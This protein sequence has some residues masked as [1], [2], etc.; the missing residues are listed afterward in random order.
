MKKIKW[1][2]ILVFANLVAINWVV[3]RFLA[4]Y[5]PMVGHDYSL[6]IPQML[7]T[8]IHLR[9]NGLSIQWYTP[10]FGGGLP[11][12]PNPN[13]SQFS[14]LELLTVLVQPWDAV[15]LSTIIYISLGG[16]ASYYLFKRVMRLH[17]TSSILGM[18]FFSANG[19]MLE[20]IA[21]GHLGY[22]TFPVIAILLVAL[23]DLSL[24]WGIAALAFAFVVTMLLHQAGYFI[25]VTFGLSMLMIFPL[26]YILRSG[27]FSWKRIIAVI[28]LGGIAALLM[29]ASKLAAVFSFMRFFP[30]EVADHYQ[31][32]P[33]MGL[34]GIALQLLGTMNLT[35]L[36][37]AARLDPNLLPKYLIFVTGGTYGY[38]EFDMSM[39]PAVFVILIAGVYRFFRN[40]RNYFRRLVTDR[41]WIAWIFL[42]L[43]TWITIEFTLA[44]GWIYPHLRNL[45]ILGSLHVNARFAAAFLFPLAL[46]AAALYDRW[47]KNWSR[48]KSILVFTLVNVIALL[49]LG[50]YFLFKDDLQQR[51]YNITES[52]EIYASILSG[53]SLEITAI[54]AEENNTQALSDHVSN[55]YPYEPIFGYLLENFHPEIEPGSVWDVSD[56]YYNMTNPAGYVFPEING[57][58]PFERI[59]VGERE[60]LEAFANHRQPDWKIPLYQLALD[61]ASGLTFV[62]VVAALGGYGIL[63]S[64]RLLSRRA[65]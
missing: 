40:P 23:L 48:K 1:P 4:F 14:I 63:R 18:V 41:K 47:V 22:Q 5:Y 44:N 56:G 34:F 17:W 19:F 58:R 33:L 57:S 30:R 49:P 7:D 16:I 36:L 38:W 12:F 61:W 60:E 3:I 15:I 59:P 37:W 24:P 65:V 54:G 39:T 9:V 8:F 42:I 53:D 13:N 25:I 28:G 51:T 55:L 27:V 50:T 26:V 46:S 20:R 29:S 32:T 62:F 10:S 35:P 43:S 6:A 31:T 45:P 11:A 21:I 64:W 2:L 52:K